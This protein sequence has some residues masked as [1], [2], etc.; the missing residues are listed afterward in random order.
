MIFKST[1]QKIR[2]VLKT[3]AVAAVALTLFSGLANA[4]TYT[5]GNLSTGATH[6]IGTA[7]PAGTTWSELQLDN[8]SLGVGVNVTAGLS[9]ADDFTVPSFSN[10]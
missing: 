8:N 7:A 2:Q 6:T 4:Q 10:T 3:T 1:L 9:V 5:N